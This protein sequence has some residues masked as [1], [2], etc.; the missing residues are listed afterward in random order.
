MHITLLKKSLALVLTIA[1]IFSTMS[2]MGYA[3][4][5][6]SAGITYFEHMNADGTIGVDDGS[7]GIQFRYKF[8]R[9]ALVSG[10][11]TA[12][13][14]DDVYD[15]I[16][17]EKAAPGEKVKAR[18]YVGTDFPVY[19]S[20]SAAAMFDPAF[21]SVSYS[22]TSAFTIATN[23]NHSTGLSISGTDG[24]GYRSNPYNYNTLR[25]KKSFLN[26]PGVAADGTESYY[27]PYNY[28]DDKGII[29]ATVLISGAGARPFSVN[30]WVYELEFTVKN[31]SYVKTPGNKGYVKTPLEFANQGKISEA[32]GAQGLVDIPRYPYGASNNYDGVSMFEYDPYAVTTPGY[33]SVFSNVTFDALAE[34]GGYFDGNETTKVVPGVIGQDKVDA[35]TVI[36]KNDDGKV[37]EG[38]SLTKGGEILKG[39]DYA[40]MVYG[41]EDITLYAVWKESVVNT[42]YT[43]EVYN[44]NPDGSYPSSPAS[45]QFK[46]EKDTVIEITSA[47]AP[48]GFVLDE[49]AANILS[50]VVKA[51]NSTILR[52]YFAR[53]QYTAT[54]HYSDNNGA[55]KDQMKLYFG[56]EIPAFDAV[57]G[58]E[59]NV[60]G[61]KFEGWSLSETA[62][63][64]VPGVMPNKDI[65]MYPMYSDIIYTYVYDANGGKFADDAELKSFV[66]KYGDVPAKFTE[67]PVKEGYE[68]SYWD[69]DLPAAVTEDL[70]FKAEYNISNY[71]VK[72][73]DKDGNVIDDATLVLEY[74]SE[75]T[76]ADV[77]EGYKAD[78]WT[79]DNGVGVEFPYTVTGDVT[80]TATEDANMYDVTFYV[81]GEVY[82]TYKL[83]NGSEV[84]LPDAPADKTGYKFATWNPDANGAIVDGAPLEFNAVFVKGEYVLS[85]NTDGGTAINPITATYG[86]NISN[87][88]P[89]ADATT[90]EGY[91]FAGWD[92]KLPETMPGVN[93]EVKALWT[94]NAY[95][96]KFVNG[97]TGAEIT[98]VSGEFGSEVNAP[99][100]P[101]VAGYTFAWDVTPPSTIPAKNEKGELMANGGVMTITAVPTANDVT[102][103][104]DTNGGEPATMDA[105]GGKANE[106]IDP[107]IAEP[108]AP[109][110]MQFIGWDD[111]TGKV[112]ATP[113]TFP[114]ESV[115][116]KA[117][118]ENLKFEAIYN[119]NGGAF[120]DGSTDNVTFEVE[121]G[122]TVPAPA[123][124]SRNGYTFTGWSPVVTTMPAKDVEFEAQWEA[125]GPVDYTITVYAVNPA[126]GELLD[127]IV[128]NHKAEAGTKL[129]ILEKGSTVPDGVTAIWYEDLYTSNSNVPDADNSN[130]VL[131]LTVALDGNNNLV[132]YFK[133]QEYSIVFDA[134]GGEFDTAPADDDRYSDNQFT[135]AGTY[136]E[137]VELPVEPTMEGYDF[138][139]W[140]DGE[141][142][143]IYK[144]EVPAFSGDV[145]YVAVWEKK[146]YDVTFT[147]TDEEGNV[148]F[149]ETVTFEHGE[150]V[151]APDYKPEDGYEFDGWDI[152]AGTKA[153]NAG[154]YSTNATLANYD[155]KYV[156]ITGVPEG[157]AIPADTTKT[158]KDGAFEVGAATV[159]E[160][161]SFE[162]WFINSATGAKADATY[163]MTAAPVTFYGEFKANTY[164]INYDVNGG[165]YLASTPVAFGTHVTTITV[166]TKEGFT[167]KGW[168]YVQGNLVTDEAGNVLDADFT[169]PAGDV[170]LKATWEENPTFHSVSYTFNISGIATAPA[171]ETNIQAGTTHALAAAPADTAEYKFTG[172]YYNGNKVTEIVMPASDVTIIGI[173]EP[174]VAETFTLTLDA[175]GGTFADGKETNETEHQA[176]ADLSG[177]NAVIP[178][179]EGY[180]FVKWSPELPATMPAEDLTLVAQWEV[181]EYTINFDSNGGSAVPSMDV[182]FGQKVTPPTQ[183]TKPG[184]DFVEWSP[185]LPSTMTDI[186]ND[187]AEMTVT[188]VW[189]AKKY[190]VSLNANGGV[191]ANGDET[192]AAEIAFETVLS[193][194]A[195]VADPTRDGYKFLGWTTVGQT[196]Y[197]TIPATQPIGGLDYTAAW[198][199]LNSTISFD[200]NGGKS[201]ADLS[202][203]T[204]ETV[205]SVPVTTKEG[206]DFQGWM[207]E[208][209]ALVTDKDGKFTSEFKMPANNVKLTASWKIKSAEVKYEFTGDVP[210]D[211]TLPT[212]GT[213]EYGA[214]VN[215][216][217]APESEGYKFDGWYNGNVPVAPGST[218]KMGEDA[219]TL[220]GKW[221]KEEVKT[222]T[223]TFSAAGG[224]FS[225]GKT[226]WTYTLKEGDAITAPTADD[227]SREGF[228]FTGWDSTVP[229]TM[230]AENLNFS[231]VWDVDDTRKNL[232]ADA[233]GGKFEDGTSVKNHK[234]N[235]GDTVDG[236]IEEPK[237]DGYKFNG[238]S[239]LE[240][241]KMPD[242]D[243]TI[244]ANWVAEVTIDPN[245]GTFADGTTAKITTTGDAIN[246][247][248]KLPVTKDKANFLGWKDTISGNTYDTIPATSD[249]PMNLVAQWDNMEQHTVTFYVGGNVHKTDS[250]YEGD[251]IVLPADPTV[252]G[253]D[254][255]GW[256]LEDG[257]TV[258]ATMGDSDLK[259]I[260]VLTPHK[261]NVTFY[262]DDAKTNVYEEYKDVAFG[263]EIEAP[264]DPTHPTNPELV[265]AGWTPAL[266]AE[267]PDND[268]EYV[269]TWKEKEVG[270]YAAHFIANGETC[271]LHI[272]AE[273]ETIPVPEDP[274]KFGYVFVGWE[275]SVPET[276]P[277]QDMTF[278]AQWEID[279]DFVSIIIGGTVIGGGALAG[280]IGTGAIIGGASIIGGILIFWGATEIAKNTFTVTYKVD[281]EVYKTY[282]VLAG[283]KIPVPA[284][285]AKNGSKFAG[286]NPE[287][288]EKMPK[289]D[290]VFEATW[291]ADAD[292]EIP[293]TGSFSGV[294]AF[295]AISAAGAFAFIATKKK[296][297]EDEE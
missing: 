8:F 4:N 47:S 102:I 145:D 275:P 88:L 237:R 27:I 238:W 211:A 17:T 99:A 121:Y 168:E 60:P 160:G 73:A 199:A 268:L 44:M 94:K 248:G 197:V 18:L 97:L 32:T 178:T 242:A 57:D 244:K 247:D 256:T 204:G 239:G 257:T 9:Y 63:L 71:T 78:A 252:T 212:G 105:I 104:F 116:L 206:H 37:L 226:S 260:A 245:G 125:V 162:G 194:V 184:Y 119:P 198:E 127:P 22:E 207:D 1:M 202:I 261:H 62:N 153:E 100:L 70:V 7:N 134:N 87:L 149:E 50:G 235:A 69:I 77:P 192:F 112:I 200:A 43:Y 103:T 142:D 107:A 89:G 232:V 225:D 120:A 264:A 297:D 181:E 132:A 164:N 40:S 276:M 95:S 234:F 278:E 45:Q 16:E 228:V 291:N 117:V 282:K 210:A 86:D 82:E 154:D 10:G 115:T 85:F 148:V 72:F 42:Y 66:Y 175:N 246:T 269:A 277:A 84:V 187:G 169:M 159:P 295:A 29:T 286:W 39:S 108:K 129:Q 265:F 136:G 101:T 156:A 6:G 230:P 219:V 12:E 144:N 233:N 76:A 266:E 90:K 188:A 151:V 53:K 255:G 174:I 24:G 54:Y 5:D 292:V 289:E 143:Y 38:W 109:E 288:P 130:N 135:V 146:T 229:N 126:T 68:F 150:D 241:G 294:A 172:W 152:P 208:S 284:D 254:F 3:A 221:V 139:G 215:V 75:V 79:L 283:T 36:P 189:E 263:S 110:G 41:Y 19:S 140:K 251:A 223:V 280:I 173:W 34:E 56:Q 176:N 133:L 30:D 61:K 236:A 55:Q 13:T 141:T 111:G 259:V 158:V 67:I 123:A 262:L 165:N 196:G 186:G 195:P 272:L 46:A 249:V 214:T 279:K 138:I 23:K 213:F 190:P 118:Y 167:F 258:P 11:D 185:A 124:P 157:G 224:Q 177:L 271:G 166:P 20:F 91:T 201:V 106:A 33:V 21:F 163:T 273:G 293:S 220:T 25:G 31:D 285:P 64:A 137:T 274:K 49:N 161:Y 193:T 28:L 93:T 179:R 80:F 52:A 2:V 113:T 48:E 83:E 180:T 191:L 131:E 26:N 203:P 128:T 59:P 92:T 296:K 270:K 96:V 182:E 222:Y 81:D 98:T 65:D 170:L 250:Y 253:F 15:W 227:V 290:L 51:D 155:V 209:G 217:A 35:S 243:T 147:V 74:G 287:V 114:A 216:A 171:T 183:P 231:A 267:M 58:G 240:D 218:F 205:E 122:A 281:G 14:T